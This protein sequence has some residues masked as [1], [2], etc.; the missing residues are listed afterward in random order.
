MFPTV[1]LSN[2]VADVPEISF[3]THW[4][5]CSVDPWTEVAT[6]NWT[7]LVSFTSSKV[8]QTLKSSL[9]DPG[10]DRGKEEGWGQ[11]KLLPLC[12]VSCPSPWLEM[13]TQLNAGGNGTGIWSLSPITGTRESY[14]SPPVRRMMCDENFLGMFLN[15]AWRPSST[16]DT[17][18]CL[19]KALST[20]ALAKLFGDG[21]VGSSF[22]PWQYLDHDL[23]ST[24]VESDW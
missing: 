11:G 23:H 13:K 1:T 12:P 8:H 14:F 22:M 2:W 3:A 19:S 24:D 16:L 17:F 10:Q 9:Q 7:F 6:G 21:L 18:L 20:S 4:S 15:R 5:G